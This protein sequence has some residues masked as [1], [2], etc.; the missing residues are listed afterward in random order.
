MKIQ[1]CYP[2]VENVKRVSFLFIPCSMFIVPPTFAFLIFYFVKVSCSCASPSTWNLSI[3]NEHFFPSAPSPL[4]W[5]FFPITREENRR[6]KSFF[7]DDMLHGIGAL[8]TN[9][10]NDVK[11]KMKLGGWNDCDENQ[12]RADLKANLRYELMCDVMKNNVRTHD[13]GE[14]TLFSSSTAAS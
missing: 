8:L 4:I 6:K 2:V 9:N 5:T 13:F 1:F 7:S 11:W 3:P 10:I 14:I 12:P